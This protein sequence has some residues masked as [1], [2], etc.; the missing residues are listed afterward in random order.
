[1]AIHSVRILDSTGAGYDADIIAGIGV[2]DNPQSG[3]D[4]SSRRSCRGNSL[5]SGSD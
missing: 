1:M 3:G 5:L 4:M 2:L